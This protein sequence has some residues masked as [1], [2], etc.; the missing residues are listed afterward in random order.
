M[1]IYTMI[2]TAIDDCDAY[3]RLS[4]GLAGRKW[5]IKETTTAYAK[6]RGF[7]E[8]PFVPMKKGVD[9]TTFT[10]SKLLTLAGFQL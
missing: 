5:Q 6:L 8:A 10:G 1:P 9:P 4:A 3:I 7:T 2:K